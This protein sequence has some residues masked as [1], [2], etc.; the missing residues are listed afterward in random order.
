MPRPP[1]ALGS[2]SNT[3]LNIIDTDSVDETPG[4]G[5]ITYDALGFNNTVYA[6]AL[7]PN[8]Q[9]VVGGDFTLA[10]GVPRQRIVRLNSDGTVDAGF[11]QPS[12]AYGANDSVRAIALQ[13]DGRIVV[14]GLFTSFNSGN[15]NHIAR[16]NNDGSLDSQFT[17][18]SGPDNAVYA[19]AATTNNATAATKIYVGGSFVTI[20]G[21]PINSHRPA[22]CRRLAG[23]RLQSRAGRQRRPCMPSPSQRRT[24]RWSSAA[25]SP[26]STAT[27]ISLTSPA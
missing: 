12:S 2:P 15:L 13:P 6:L 23:H 16:L 8:N 7:Q 10:N 18:G 21:T 3:V 4:Q 5:D 14:G 19:L 20:G 9:L 17:P 22:Q 1:C 26:P 27:P 24:A 11:S 25:I